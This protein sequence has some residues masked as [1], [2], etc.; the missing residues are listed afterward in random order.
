MKI[1]IH[2]QRL[3]NTPGKNYRLAW[4]WLYDYELNG[5]RISYDTHLSSLVSYLKRKYPSA[6]IVKDW[7]NET[8]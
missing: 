1:T 3:D 5:Q 8:I 7:K 4:R 6:E 2:R